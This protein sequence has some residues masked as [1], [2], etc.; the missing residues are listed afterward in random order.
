MKS[1]SK[2]TNGA[3]HILL[4]DDDQDDCCFLREALEELPLLSHLT[5]VYDGEQLMLLLNKK[6]E[7]HFNVIF[8]DLNMP[9]KNG[10]TC[11]EEIKTDDNLRN[12]P[13]IILS[14]SFEERTADLHYKNGEHYYICKP[15]ELSLIGENK[16]TQPPR[17]DFFLSYLNDPALID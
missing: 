15:A 10:F 17:K 6:S 7:H 1:N 3:L 9:N 14:T 16:I 11:L 2:I 4:A 5:S 8:I 13:T 12:I